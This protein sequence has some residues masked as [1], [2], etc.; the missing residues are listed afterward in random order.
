MD[1]F[2]NSCAAYDKALEVGEDYLIHLNYAVTLLAN[3]EV[4][5]ARI[6]FKKF[7]QLVGSIESVDV[8]ED[9][10]TQASLLRNTLNGQT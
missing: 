9:V 4:E 10:R 1:D 2:D 5:K 6:H 7:E 8:D 3:D